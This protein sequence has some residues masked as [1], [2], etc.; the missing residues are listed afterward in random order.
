MLGSVRAY[1]HH[2]RSKDRVSENEW[3]TVFHELEQATQ[4]F[5][6]ISAEL[7]DALHQLHQRIDQFTLLRT[8]TSQL[9]AQS[10]LDGVIEATMDALWQKSPLIHNKGIDDNGRRL[11]TR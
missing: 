5:N 4:N 9:H 3:A 2:Y 11:L 10:S 8:I 6:E 7:E 1:L